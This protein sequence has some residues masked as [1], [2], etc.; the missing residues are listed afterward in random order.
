MKKTLIKIIKDYTNIEDEKVLFSLIKQGKIIVN[1]EK[2]FLPYAKFNDNN[3]NIQILESK[4]YVS[5]GAYK[6]LGA[7]DKFNINFDNKVCLDIGSSTG[8]FVQVMLINNAKKVYAV[9]VGTNQLDYSLRINPKV[10]VYEK[11]NL[12]NLNSS[13]FLEDIDF[14]TCDVSFI[15]IKN[16][17][18]VCSNFLKK[19][20]LLMILIK[21]EFEAPYNLVQKGGYVSEDEHPKI[22]DE[23]K[24]YAKNKNFKLLQIDK[25]PI[26]GQKS[27]NIEY[28]TLFERE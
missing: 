14:V 28:I 11:T 23:I 16:V 15:S 22:I 26:V 27:K 7:I 10:T 6:L 13:F 20:V 4:E 19:G 3:L 2:Q 1:G 21:P 12:K 25:S 18:D 5:R 8:G 17:F 24:E 9:D